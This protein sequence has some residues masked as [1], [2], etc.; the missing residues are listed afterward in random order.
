[1]WCTIYFLRWQYLLYFEQ[2]MYFSFCGK[3]VKSNCENGQ[4]FCPAFLST[5]TV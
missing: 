3:M 1:M 4:V 5:E 2:Y